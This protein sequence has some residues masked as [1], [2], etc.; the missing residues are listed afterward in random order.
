M[1]W[2]FAGGGMIGPRLGSIVVT[3]G[4]C[5]DALRALP[6]DDSAGSSSRVLF[7]DGLWLSWSASRSSSSRSSG[8][9]R[10]CIRGSRA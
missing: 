6:S 8:P 9:S 3:G 5:C 10:G 2:A 7:A 1:V 4:H